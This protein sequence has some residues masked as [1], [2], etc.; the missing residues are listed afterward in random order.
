[1]IVMRGLITPTCE[2]LKKIAHHLRR[3]GKAELS[4]R[5]LLLA[6]A[7][8]SAK[9]SRDRRKR[10]W[11][12]ASSPGSLALLKAYKDVDS[13]NAKLFRSKATRGIGQIQAALRRSR[14]KQQE[15]QRAKKFSGIGKTNGKKGLQFKQAVIDSWTIPTESGFGNTVPPVKHVVQEEVQ[16]NKRTNKQRMDDESKDVGAPIVPLNPEHGESMGTTRRARK[17]PQSAKTAGGHPRTTEKGTA[18]ASRQTI[19]MKTE[20]STT[21]QPSK[22]TVSTAGAEVGATADG[23]EHL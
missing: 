17:A 15:K 16:N 4:R 22:A 11:Q 10:L 20:S 19:L 6:A 21:D 23:K 7:R 2:N 13:S 1:M 12:H 3:L 9:N 14:K 8:A 18:T 5:Q